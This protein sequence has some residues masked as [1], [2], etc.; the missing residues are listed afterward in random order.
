MIPS[1]HLLIS[2]FKNWD[3]S[4]G[5]FPFDEFERQYTE[6]ER[7]RITDAYRAAKIDAF[8]SGIGRPHKTSEDYLNETYSQ[9]LHTTK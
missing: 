9:V 2:A 5:P 4:K 3:Y 1:A 6:L 7:N 8:Y